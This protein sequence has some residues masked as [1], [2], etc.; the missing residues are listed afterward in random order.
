M[1]LVL[2]NIDAVFSIQK[3][4]KKGKLTEPNLFA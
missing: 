4:K 2:Q 3:K 1:F